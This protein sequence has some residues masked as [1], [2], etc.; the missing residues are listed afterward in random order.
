MGSQ[1]CSSDRSRR[2][3]AASIAGVSRTWTYPTKTTL[4]GDAS[5]A[6]YRA[7]CIWFAPAPDTHPLDTDADLAYLP[8][9]PYP[10]AYTAFFTPTTFAGH[11]WPVVKLMRP[12]VR[13]V[14]GDEA[15]GVKQDTGSVFTLPQTV[16]MT[17]TKRSLQRQALFLAQA[18]QERLQQAEQDAA[19]CR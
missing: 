12:Q 15:M 19:F 1:C 11:L 14:G 13:D 10:A 7:K 8:D 9:P 3:A 5:N 2:C 17:C 4:P 6:E 16:V 18:E